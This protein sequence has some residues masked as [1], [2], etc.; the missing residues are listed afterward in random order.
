MNREAARRHAQRS[1]LVVLSIA[2]AE[3]TPKS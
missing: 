1:K 3:L 2:S